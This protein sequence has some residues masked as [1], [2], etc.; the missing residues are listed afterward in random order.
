MLREDNFIFFILL[1]LIDMFPSIIFKDLY[2]NMQSIED[3]PL[4]CNLTE[5]T[6][7]LDLP[8]QFGACTQQCETSLFLGSLQR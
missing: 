1:Y 7:I 8:G 6:P 4:D 5:M 3:C 2:S